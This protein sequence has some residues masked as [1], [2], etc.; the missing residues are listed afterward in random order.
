MKDLYSHAGTS[1]AV[2][3]GHQLEA[4]GT[5]SSSTAHITTACSS[6]G[7]ELDEYFAIDL[8]PAS[9]LDTSVLEALP[10]AL[11]DKILK[12]YS[13]KASESPRKVA[14]SVQPEASRPAAEESSSY[15]VVGDDSEFVA[16]FRA[17]LKDWVDHS[18]DSAIDKDVEK[19]TDYLV[20]I[21]RTNLT[22]VLCVLRY[23]R[24]LLTQRELTMWYSAFNRLLDG[25][26]D[27][28]KSQYHGTLPIC[29]IEIL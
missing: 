24:R 28:V 15:C 10:A 29:E 20:Q 14:T 25:I 27:Q 22:V 3:L 2:E 11:K 17:Y 19:V 21:S 6:A 16:S 26:Q 8:P 7:S 12:T 5:T 1:L 23:F 4:V 9:Q 18:L 13:D